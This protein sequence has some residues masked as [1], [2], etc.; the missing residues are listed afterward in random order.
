ML[1][2]IAEV[3]FKGGNGGN[4][5]VSF[6]K[7]MKGPD[8]GNGG[9]GGNLYIES[10]SDLKLLNQ[11]SRETEF[12]A[13]KGIPGGSNN[14]SGK[15]GEDL[16]IFL[17]LGTSVINKKTNS[18]IWDL[19]DPGMRILLCKGGK[20]GLGNWE[21]RSADNPVPRYGQSGKKGEVKEL[22]LS[23]KL[24]ADFGF[25]GLP[26]AG[27]TSLLNE[28]TGSHKKT[29]NYSFT[30]LAAA[31]GVYKQKVLADIPGLIEGASAGKG[32]G[33]GFLKHIEK[34]K[35]ILHC[36][37]CESNDVL[38]DYETVR[39]ELGKFNQNL[40]TKKEVI[41]LTKSDLV[42]AEY[43]EIAK[44]LLKDKS[45]DIL[46]VSIDDQVSIQDL[47]NILQSDL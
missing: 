37:S 24:I 45:E 32:L 1:I 40:L 12:S 41:L 42:D 16:T 7:H 35:V 19:S 33:I 31:L 17:P 10:V 9:D 21:Y 25:I 46:T 30:T 14:R 38:K 15:G 28:I 26:N 6:R 36:I 5:K 47:K 22:I 8:G 44:E 13:G 4:G 27:K 3:I 11:F 43:L 34:V 18:E 39:T 20:G 23:L 29:A 2:D